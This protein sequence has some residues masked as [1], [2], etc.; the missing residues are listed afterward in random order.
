MT[1][2]PIVTWSIPLA[3]SYYL[4]GPVAARVMGA[5]WKHVTPGGRL[6]VAN[7]ATGTPGAGY[8]EMSMDW[9]L[10]YRSEADLEGG[11]SDIP[12]GEIESAQS[13]SDPGEAVHYLTLTR[14]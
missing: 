5:L 6:I 4:N 8:M 14:R 2:I 10:T 1:S 9:W 7:F 12:A 11:M 3:C 13:S